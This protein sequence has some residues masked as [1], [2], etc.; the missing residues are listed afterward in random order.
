MG[1]IELHMHNNHICLLNNQIQYFIDK[2]KHAEEKIKTNNNTKKKNMTKNDL[3][4][5]SK[6]L[7]IHNN[8]YKQRPCITHYCLILNLKKMVHHKI[9]NI[10]YLQAKRKK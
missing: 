5:I 4:S 3:S 2:I 8:N 1:Y 9:V 10:I 6:K 7:R